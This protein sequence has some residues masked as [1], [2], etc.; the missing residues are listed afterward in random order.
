MNKT[1]L[2]EV[3]GDKS[4]S[5]RSCSRA[6]Q[7]FA[8]RFRASETADQSWLPGLEDE[9]DRYVRIY[10]TRGMSCVSS[11]EGFGWQHTNVQWAQQ[12]T[13]GM[14]T[15]WTKSDDKVTMS[16]CHGELVSV[17]AG[18]RAWEGLRCAEVPM[19][20]TSYACIKPLLSPDLTHLLLA[21]QVEVLA[22]LKFAL[23]QPWSE[24]KQ[25]LQDLEFSP[26]GKFLA[27]ILCSGIV[28]HGEKAPQRAGF[29]NIIIVL[30]AMQRDLPTR[31]A[32]SLDADFFAE[33]LAW[34]ADSASLCA[35]GHCIE[36]VA[37]EGPRT[38]M[39]TY[40]FRFTN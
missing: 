37:E 4:W 2:T 19:F 21:G 18:D 15:V 29:K 9:S 17:A 8:G 31:A 10:E 6:Y 25:W 39:H 12:G 7:S 23:A 38:N 24:E 30:D 3:P 5:T 33:H 13:D 36:D 28:K 16:L 14:L 32:L 26:D 40:V 11:F 27:A 35:E 20:T 34:A 1:I 22:D